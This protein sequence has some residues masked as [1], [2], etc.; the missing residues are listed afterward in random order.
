MV[1]PR[2]N[3]AAHDAAYLLDPFDL[4]HTMLVW[5]EEHGLGDLLTIADEPAVLEFPLFLLFGIE[6]HP[7]RDESI[8]GICIM[9]R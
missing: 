8:P 2:F 5:L 9:I 1:W 7:G 6:G 4:A 3:L